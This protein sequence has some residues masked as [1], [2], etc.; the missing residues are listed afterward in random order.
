MSI[1]TSKKVSNRICE[2]N[3]EDILRFYVTKGEHY[4][5]TDLYSMNYRKNSEEYIRLY[6]TFRNQK[7]KA[8]DVEFL[9]YIEEYID[10]RKNET[11]PDK[12][13]EFRWMNTLSDEEI[14]CQVDAVEC[15]KLEPNQKWHF[16]VSFCAYKLVVEVD[17]QFKE[18]TKTKVSEF[19]SVIKAW[20]N[21][22]CPELRLWMFE[23]AM[24]NK[25][26]TP[27]NVQEMYRATV[28]KQ[29]KRKTDSKWWSECWEKVLRV[30]SAA[31]A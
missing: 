14:L 9:Q 19:N 13:K 15:R 16:L 28:D 24:D 10:D 17:K 18:R 21:I 12:W 8:D 23:A 27:A 3:M 30:I 26:I 6:D 11:N 2:I 5:F 31:K 25:I 29:L 7:G 20:L 22:K 1:I 4:P